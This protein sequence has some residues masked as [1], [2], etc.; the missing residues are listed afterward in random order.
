[1][2]QVKNAGPA[3]TALRENPV[4]LAVVDPQEA[5]RGWMCH[6]VYWLYPATSSSSSHLA[7]RF[8]LVAV[9]EHSS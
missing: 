1:M 9:T 4:S 7:C 5:D 8:V 2:M 6:C 3:Y